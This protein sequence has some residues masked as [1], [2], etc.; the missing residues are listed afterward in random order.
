MPIK[1]EQTERLIEAIDK[2][3]FII[4]TSKCLQ[5]N[6]YSQILMG[7]LTSA[8]SNNEHLNKIYNELKN[9]N[10]TIIMSALLLG[11]TK[12]PEKTLQ[13]YKEII[14]MYIK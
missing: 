7:L 1:T 14:N 5:K 11:A 3:S 8:N 9:L 2:L 13:D 4:D 12:N 10:K 6:D